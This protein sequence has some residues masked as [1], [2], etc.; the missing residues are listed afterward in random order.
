MG[1]SPVVL[2]WAPLETDPAAKYFI[3]GG[4]G[5][6][7][8]KKKTKGRGNET[9]NKR[10][11]FRQITTVGSCMVILLGLG[12]SLRRAEVTGVFIHQLSAGTG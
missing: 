10:R 4:G 3:W 1:R 2:V 11:V 12:S 5:G 6:G 9:Y 8:A 7:D